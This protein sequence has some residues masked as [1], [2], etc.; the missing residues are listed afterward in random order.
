MKVVTDALGFSLEVEILVRDLE[1]RGRHVTYEDENG[2]VGNDAPHRIEID[3]ALYGSELAEVIAH[4][5]YH[6]FY[7]LRHRITTDE[8]TEA[9]TF[10]HLVRRLHEVACPVS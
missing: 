2:N 7:S 8:E 6:L 5:V 10:G 4:E 1:P 9:E 3:T